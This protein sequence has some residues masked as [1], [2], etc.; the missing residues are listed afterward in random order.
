MESNLDLMH[1]LGNAIARRE[2]ATDAHNYR[3]TLYPLRLAETIGRPRGKKA[4]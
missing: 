1:A 4:D 2:S 3:V